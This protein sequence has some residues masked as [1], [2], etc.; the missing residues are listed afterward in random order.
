[1]LAYFGT[2][3]D[4]GKGTARMDVDGVEGVGIEW[5]DKKGRLNLLKVNSPCDGTKEVSV[6][7]LFLG[8][9][10]MTVLLVED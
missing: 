4:W 8:I 9:P 1:M 5:S 3:V 7:K 6:N 2:D 10:D